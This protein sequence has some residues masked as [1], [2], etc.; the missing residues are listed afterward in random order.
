MLIYNNILF[1]LIA[2]YLC[3]TYSNAFSYS[4]L[5]VIFW[6]SL[7][8]GQ[9]AFV[10]NTIS[11]Y[12][13]FIIKLINKKYALQSNWCSTYFVLAYTVPSWFYLVQTCF[14]F[15]HISILLPWI[16]RLIFLSLSLVFSL[17]LYPS[18][19]LSLFLS[20]SLSPIITHYYSLIYLSSELN[21]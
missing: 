19:S 8:P 7:L 1:Y 10:L 3:R 21:K 12:P 20:H 5:R 11:L 16:S 14:G 6:C 4:K 13:S 17:S 2:F 9:F 18:P 15:L